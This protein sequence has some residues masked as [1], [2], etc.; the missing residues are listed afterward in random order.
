M[1]SADDP[2]QST[3]AD[4]ADRLER[5]IDKQ[6]NT[7]AEIDEKAAHT[8]RLV[9]ILLAL[10]FTLLT[11]VLREGTE[12]LG[13]VTAGVQWAFVLGLGLTLLSLGLSI[14]TY[15]SSR[16]R[17]GLHHE[18]AGFL[19]TTNRPVTRSDHLQM[20][21]GSYGSIVA[22]N[23]RVLEMNARRFKYSLTSL[24][25]GICFLA[26]AGT[27][28]FASVSG[29]LA[30]TA[31]VGTTIVSGFLSWY[32]LQEKFMRLPPHSDDND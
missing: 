30:A 16:C 13:T 4:A 25:C 9:G 2:P 14:I 28:Y 15:L 31:V 32:I 26:V 1:E 18:V 20:V 5:T 10:V 29:G 3:Y 17:V 6:L 12:S 23:E 11:L 19:T 8:T 24:L 22:E 27:L 7:I 21:V